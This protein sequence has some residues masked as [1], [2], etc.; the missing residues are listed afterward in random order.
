MYNFDQ[1]DLYPHKKC[2]TSE[3][4]THKFKNDIMM[5]EM[6]KSLGIE[7]FTEGMGR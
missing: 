1:C 2:Q 5:E 6:T 4:D 7:Y 3:V